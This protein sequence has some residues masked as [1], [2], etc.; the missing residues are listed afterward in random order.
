MQRVKPNTAPIR[1]KN[2][3][4]K[5]MIEIHRHCK[6]HDK[7]SSF[8]IAAKKHPSDDSWCEK[9]ETIVDKRLEFHVATSKNNSSRQVQLNRRLPLHNKDRREP[10]LYRELAIIE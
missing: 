5:E 10:R 3:R 4:R 2:G 8:P 7:P 6:Q 1:I 9:M